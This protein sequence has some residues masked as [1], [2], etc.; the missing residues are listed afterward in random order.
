MSADHTHVRPWRHIDRRRSRRIMV[1]AVPVG[2]DAPITVQSMTNTPTSDAAATIAQIRQLE[3]A[4]ADIV[5]VSCPDEASTAA[6][7][8]IAREVRVP[9][10]ADIHFHYKRGIEAARAGAACLRINPGN[11]GS[12][13]RVREV[14]QAAKDHG[15]SMRIGVNA[16]SLEKELLEKYGEPCPEAMVE[17]ALNHARILQDHDFHEFK[18][19]V[20]ASDPFLT[21]A[22]YHQLADAIDCPL[23]VGVTEAGPLRTGTIKSS[24]AMG[25]LLWAGIG[26]TIRVSLAADPVEEI[27]VGFDILKSLGLRHRGV[28]IIACP[29]CARQ[30]FDVIRTV[31]ILEERLAHVTTPMSLSIIGCVVNGPG[32]ALYTDVGFTGGG[33][34]SGMMYLNG[35]IARKLANADMV[36]EIV[37][38]VERKAAELEAARAA[39]KVAAE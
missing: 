4:G 8:T 34:G 22:A 31:G 13:D 3:E 18:I 38:M 20:K 32:E 10:V 35:A 1:G 25:N 33:A 9:L 30:G 19:S 39:E 29:S 27:K 16:G 24:I 23:H 2:G 15:C 36:E 6:F 21:V 7:R 5:R 14:V 17:S 11:I 26:D 28:N 12:S 37:D